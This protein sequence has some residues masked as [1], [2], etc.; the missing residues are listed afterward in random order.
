MNTT[1]RGRPTAAARG[2]T[3]AAAASRKS[4]PAIAHAR[5]GVARRSRRWG[6]DFFLSVVREA[7]PSLPRRECRRNLSGVRGHDRPDDHATGAADL[8]DGR[9]WRL[10]LDEQ[11][12]READLVAGE[13]TRARQA[14]AADLLGIA[15]A[16]D[17]LVADGGEEL[18]LQGQREHVVDAA[19]AREVLDAP[20]D[21]ASEALSVRVPRHRDRGDLGHARG[22]FLERATGEDL[23][24]RTLCDDVVVD[25]Q[26]DHL[27][28]A[29]QHLSFRGERVVQ[30]RDRDRVL[31]TCPTHEHVRGHQRTSSRICSPRASSSL[32]ATR[33]GSSRTV[34]SPAVSTS[35]PF[36]CA[37]LTTCAAV[38]IT[39][40]PQMKPVPRTCRMRLVRCAISPSSCPNQ[41]PVSR[42]CAR[43]A[44][45]D[46]RSSTCSATDAT[47]GPPP[48]VVP[49]SPYCMA[50]AMASV[51]ST[52]PIG[53][54]P[55]SGLASVTMSG[56]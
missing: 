3:A 40:K 37:S 18:G 48:N 8:F 29:E 36:A 5:R 11:I 15:R 31:R 44:G 16:V 6:I 23:T 46:N 43:S 24:G 33:G 39:S 53:R 52:A 30:P 26:R 54:P 10:L 21:R 2:G 49:W 20:H 28:R 12:A 17:A 7:E 27:R 47:K 19:H 41:A 38:P 13:A 25:G 56:V 42:T 50:L 55:A 1:S 14:I 32:V 22:V 45:S 35:R 4:A 34:Y 9:L 51:I